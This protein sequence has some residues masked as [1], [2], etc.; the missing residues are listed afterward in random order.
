ML[1]EM[2]SPERSPAQSPYLGSL[3]RPG[4]EAGVVDALVAVLAEQEVLALV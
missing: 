4:V 2:L 3:V 1:V